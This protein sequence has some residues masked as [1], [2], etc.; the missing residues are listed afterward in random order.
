MND[1]IEML[2]KQLE[3]KEGKLKGIKHE[4]LVINESLEEAV[5]VETA[6]INLVLKNSVVP[7]INMI[8]DRNLNIVGI[9]DTEC[10]G[11][12]AVYTVASSYGDYKIKILARDGTVVNSAEY[13]DNDGGES[14]KSFY[15]EVD[16]LI[17][18]D[19]IPYCEENKYKYIK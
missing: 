4:M 19:I 1:I 15:D 6:K 13:I 2:M 8:H 7:I 16:R 3:E 9:K 11:G 5:R 14:L 12:E 10:I 17:R 18:F